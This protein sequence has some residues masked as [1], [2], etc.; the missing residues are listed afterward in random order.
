MKRLVEFG[1]PMT[2]EYRQPGLGVIWAELSTLRDR[3]VDRAER[4]GAKLYG[5]GRINRRIDMV[6]EALNLLEKAQ[7]I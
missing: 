1:D 2:A 7:E 3:E 5:N 6:E 4:V